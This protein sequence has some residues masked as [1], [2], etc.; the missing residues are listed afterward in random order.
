MYLAF[1]LFSSYLLSTYE[2]IKNIY[3]RGTT[4]L[5][6]NGKYFSST[7]NLSCNDNNRNCACEEYRATP[8][9]AHII[10]ITYTRR[11]PRLLITVICTCYSIFYT[12]WSIATTSKHCCWIN[13]KLCLVNEYENS[14][15]I[16][17]IQNITFII[18]QFSLNKEL[19]K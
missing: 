7:L 18:K 8:A 2:C 13:W 6:H 15:F 17:S 11:A 3:S 19:S 5:L 12:K 14:K 4:T 9:R 10:I 16:L 1:S